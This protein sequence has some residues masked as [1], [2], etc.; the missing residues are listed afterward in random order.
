MTFNPEGYNT[1]STFIHVAQGGALLVL[2]L[3]EA[4][5]KESDGKIKL[6]SP[7]ALL[8]GPAAM[9]LAIL[10]F[11]G[12]WSIKSALFSLHIQ[13]GFYIFI[14]LACFYASAGLSQ[15][16]FLSSGETRR[17]WH[18]L[19]LVFLAVIAFLYFCVPGKVNPEAERE[20]LINHSAL[21]LTLFFA[22]ISK[23]I[24]GLRP[25]RKFHIIWVSLLLVTAFQLLTYR[26]TPGAF[27][28][29]TVGLRTELQP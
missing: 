20:A 13:R 28:F 3:T 5:A 14:S 22:V 17:A 7:A 11:L 12:G 24:H 10:Y 21:G 15:L 25:R 26:E 2:G 29:H 6:A 27:D 18:Y 16:N 1:A 19:F 9:A 4:F 8:A 23:F